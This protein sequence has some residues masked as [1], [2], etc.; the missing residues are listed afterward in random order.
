MLLVGLYDSWYPPAGNVDTAPEDPIYSV[1]V[2]T[3]KSNSQMLLLSRGWS[4]RDST[5]E[6]GGGWTG[7]G[8]VGAQLLLRLERLARVQE[9]WG[10]CGGRWRV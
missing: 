6:R 3:T 9:E 2:V 5:S 4:V 7:T 8:M 10:S 1:T